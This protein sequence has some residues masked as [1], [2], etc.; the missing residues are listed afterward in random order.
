MRRFSRIPETLL[1]LVLLVLTALQAG[2]EERLR[3]ST[4]TS[5]ENSGLLTV[6]LPPF[7]K[8]CACKVDV[9]AVGTG[10]ALKLGEASDVDVVFVPEMNLGMMTHP[11]MEALRDRCRRVVSI[12]SLGSLHSPEMILARIYEE[13]Q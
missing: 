13:L 7:E 10:K 1:V 11:I 5:T 6:L 8:K 12:P 4:T 2:A 3:M 9:V